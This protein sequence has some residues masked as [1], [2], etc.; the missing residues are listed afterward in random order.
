MFFFKTLLSYR[1]NAPIY[2]YNGQKMG[3]R[4]IARTYM[5]T[6]SKPPTLRKSMKR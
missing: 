3:V 6:V 2:I 1:S 4:I 5:I